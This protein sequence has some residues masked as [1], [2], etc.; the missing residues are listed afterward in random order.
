MAVIDD[1]S[2]LAADC[3]CHFNTVCRDMYLN[4]DRDYWQNNQ[5]D[6]FERNRHRL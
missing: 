4:R 5:R 1:L 6:N 2:V 3:C